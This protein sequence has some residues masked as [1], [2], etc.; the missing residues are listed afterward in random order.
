V[1]VTVR[2]LTELVRGNLLGDD[3][4]V[5][6][7]ARTLHEA[8][9]GDITFLDNVKHAAKLQQSRASAAVVPAGLPACGKTLIEVAD[10]LMSFVAIVQLLQG[11]TAPAATGI[12]ARA[13]VHASARIGA[14]PSILPFALVGENTTIGKRCRLHAGAV[15]GK[16]CRLG[17]D[18]VLHPHVVLYDDT[19]LG[20][21]VIIHAN[22]SIGADGFG[23]RFQL[24]RHVKIP[25]LGNVV[26]GNDVEIGAGS[27]IDRGTFGPTTIGDGTKID[28]LVQVA[29]NC[30]IG[31]HNV[32]A[33]QVGIAG[34]CSTGNYV[35]LGGQAGISDHI[36]IGDGAMFGAKTG[37][38]DDVPA[39]KRMW[40][41]PAH[42]E[43]DAARIVYCLKKLPSMRK[44]LLRV[45]KELKLNDQP[46]VPP[47]RSPE[48]PAA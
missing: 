15:I 3:H 35:M 47:V 42:E 20:D 8:Q 12:D 41:Y 39:G 25:Q 17:D 5:I 1:T 23:Y 14:D 9:P 43:R 32:F 10:P 18:V 31:K 30:Q 33:A 44:D 22:A 21:R 13:V 27:A 40:L 16:N 36:K 46:D 28:N 24:G 26:I 45:L 4:L 19:V 34:S 7:A 11:K 37:I 29:H 38:F 48:A 2:Q 6:Q